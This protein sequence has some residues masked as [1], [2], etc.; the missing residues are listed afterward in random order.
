MNKLLATLLVGA[1]ALS[2]N[3]TVFAADAAAPAV[4]TPA[5][6]AMKS[7][8]AKPMKKMHHHKHMKKAAPAAA[9]TPA[10]K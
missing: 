10:A 9:E 2:I 8:T 6:D 1:F 5:A 7:E 3:T 4:A